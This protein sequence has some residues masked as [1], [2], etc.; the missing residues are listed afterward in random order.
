ME[1]LSAED[2]RELRANAEL[3]TADPFGD[4][5]LLLEDGDYLKLFRVKR[6]WTSARLRP[7]AKRFANNTR[8]LADLD[9]PVPSVRALYQIPAIARTAVRYAPLPG[10]TL[11]D[12]GTEFDADI[13]LKLGAFYKDLHSKG[14]YH[15]SLHL[16]NVVL[17]P[18]RR[19]GLIDVADLN[20]YWGS[21][22]R[23]LRLRN[24]QHLFRY[25]SDRAVIAKFSNEFNE[26]IADNKLIDSVLA[27]LSEPV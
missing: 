2:Y 20:I 3:V 22:P 17:T 19:L 11:R 24:F 18:E 4:K 25:H 21:L 23:R 15:R 8:R 27:M 1:K 12:L 14:I 6:L 9:I 10:K 7:Y 26:G 16:G 5:V 13:A